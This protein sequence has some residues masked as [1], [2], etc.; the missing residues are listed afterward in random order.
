M[1]ENTNQLKAGLTHEDIYDKFKDEFLKI[2]DEVMGD[3][4]TQY[5]P[6]AEVDLDT[7]IYYRSMDYIAGE[8]KENTIFGQMG[9]RFRQRIFEENKDMII[10][11]LNQDKLDEIENL[12]EEIKIANTQ[13][14]SNIR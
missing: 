4:I 12:K 8:F 1:E 9:K 11:Q 6:H 3:V 14:W 2:A 5:L 13:Y 10:G 7:N